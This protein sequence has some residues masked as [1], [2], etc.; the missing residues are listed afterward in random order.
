M[1]SDLV[2]TQVPE[3]KKSCGFKTL[4]NLRNTYCI[5]FGGKMGSLLLLPPN[6]VYT[7][8]Q[9]KLHFGRFFFLNS[10]GRSIKLFHLK[11]W[12]K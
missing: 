2:H 7:Q 9:N 1:S 3:F 6:M 11:K 10:L 4:R 5:F 8:R 12:Y